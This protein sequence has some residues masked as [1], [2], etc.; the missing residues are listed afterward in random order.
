MFLRFLLL[1]DTLMIG[2]PLP[3]LVGVVKP[4]REC[5]SA[6]GGGVPLKRAARPLFL[7]GVAALFLC[8]LG[9][10]SGRFSF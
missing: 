10:G 3:V 5:T 4:Q 6:I 2:S 1:F 8:A 7:V 9:F